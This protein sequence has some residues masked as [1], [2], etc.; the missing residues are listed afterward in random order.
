M[1]SDLKPM[2]TKELTLAV[3]QLLEHE[4]IRADRRQIRRRQLRRRLREQ[5]KANADQLRRSIEVIKWCIVGI[6][7]VMVLSLV[8]LIAVVWQIGNEAER[9]SGEVESIKGEA[10]KIV[11]EI[12]NEADRIRDKLQNPIRSIGS[13]IGGQ[14]DQRIGNALGL[15]EE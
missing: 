8:I 10:E 5:R 15:E 7:T 3:N 2:S 12:S 6:T 9:I 1:E 11:T 14:L 13:A 4:R